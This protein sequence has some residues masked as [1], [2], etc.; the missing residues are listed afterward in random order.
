MAANSSPISTPSGTPGTVIAATSTARTTSQPTITARRGHRSASRDRNT[1]PASHG[2]YPAANATAAS[3]GDPVRPY[4]ST[5]SATSAS[6]SPVA[7]STTEPHKTRNSR[8][9]NTVPNPARAGVASAGITGPAAGPRARAP[10]LARS[11][12]ATT[13][14][15]W[16]LQPRGGLVGQASAPI[17]RGRVRTRTRRPADGMAPRRCS[18]RFRSTTAAS[19]Q[20]TSIYPLSPPVRQ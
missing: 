16:C 9:A 19:L 12:A 15:R 10:G 4:T 2:R 17:S 13:S 3:S 11:K 8:T 7:D 14:S 1:P 18:S 5:A 6:R 20:V